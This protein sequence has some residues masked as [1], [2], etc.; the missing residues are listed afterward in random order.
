MT[1][2]CGGGLWLQ[3]L[4]DETSPAIAEQ[5]LIM[6]DSEMGLRA[7]GSEL[8]HNGEVKESLK[9]CQPDAAAGDDAALGSCSAALRELGRRDEALNAALSGARPLKGQ[10][11]LLRKLSSSFADPS[12]AQRLHARAAR[13]K[14]LQRL[15]DGAEKLAKMVGDKGRSALDASRALQKELNRITYLRM[16]E[17]G[18]F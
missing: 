4:T 7:K 6:S 8:Y 18:S 12:R 13:I 14:A 3:R 5:S 9:I 10:N 2:I 1:T 11:A 15:R 17:Q 16:R